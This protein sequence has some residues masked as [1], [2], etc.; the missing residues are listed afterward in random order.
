VPD[1]TN[2]FASVRQRTDSPAAQGNTHPV[3]H[4]AQALVQ[5]PSVSTGNGSGESINRFLKQIKRK[6][7]EKI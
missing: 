6:A 5:N 3:M 2:C 4:R 1:F 7:N